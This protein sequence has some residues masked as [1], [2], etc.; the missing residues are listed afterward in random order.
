MVNKR[1]V[2]LQ[3]E[4]TAA[5]FLKANGLEI[6]DRNYYFP[7][8]ELDIIARNG[9]YLVVVEVKYRSSLRY[10]N[11]AEAVTRA[12]QNKIILGTKY[13]CTERQISL[14]TPIRFDVIAICGTKIHWIQHAFC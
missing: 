14:H 13:Y 10:G 3:K 8:G 9:D 6:L 11:P 5:E 2:G 1:A 7:G 4:K 12:K